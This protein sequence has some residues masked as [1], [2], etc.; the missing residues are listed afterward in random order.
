MK[1]AYDKRLHF[2]AGFI[3]AVVATFVAFF[4]SLPPALASVVGQA[5]AWVAG[6]LK[7]RKD[8]R[9]NEI[10]RREGRA[11]PHTVETADI[12]WTWIG[13]VVGALG[14]YL[15]ISAH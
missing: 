7:E 13:G 3:V 14:A 15:L 6:W 4:A 1:I 8:E 9:L 2:A 10:A 12:V 5:A 11:E